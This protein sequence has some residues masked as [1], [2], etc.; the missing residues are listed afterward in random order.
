LCDPS[1]TREL[2]PIIPVAQRGRSRLFGAGAASAAGLLSLEVE[3]G[4]PGTWLASA[5]G[6]QHAVKRAKSM[7]FLVG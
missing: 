6:R 3:V 7:A 4:T 1:C 5:V 2:L